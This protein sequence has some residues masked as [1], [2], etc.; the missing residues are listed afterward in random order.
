M[1]NLINMTP[2]PI[3]IVDAEGNKLQTILPSGNTIRL[4]QRTERVT[5]I[6]GIPISNTVY[7]DA[8]G[9]PHFQEETYYI[10]SQLIKTALPQRTDLLVPAE[11]LRDANGNIIG[12][13]S[14]GQ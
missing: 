2:H 13:Q 11:M 1:T 14:L 8:L 10:V 6:N 7:R 9:L 4:T 12:C 3:F 5:A